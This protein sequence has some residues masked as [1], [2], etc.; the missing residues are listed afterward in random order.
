MTL[1]EQMDE[2]TKKL[3]L[4]DF[5]FIEDYYYSDEHGCFVFIVN[6][7][8]LDC[9]VMICTLGLTFEYRVLNKN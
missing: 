2:I 4:I 3:Q 5:D 7:N 9:T 1:D 8:L 6:K